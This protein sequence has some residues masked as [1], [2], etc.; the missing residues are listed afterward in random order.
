[1]APGWCSAETREDST[2]S[3][4]KS[5]RVEASSSAASAVAPGVPRRPSSARRRSASAPVSRWAA[6]KARTVSGCARDT[7][8]H[9]SATVADRLNAARWRLSEANNVRSTGLAR[10]SNP[11][12]TTPGWAET[13]SAHSVLKARNDSMMALTTGVANADRPPFWETDSDQ[14]PCLRSRQR[15][16]HRPRLVHA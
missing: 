12:R 13:S 7:R 16:P 15:P 11:P 2:A 6:S 10:A 5:S 4:R 3:H 1:M 8:E 14:R 9:P